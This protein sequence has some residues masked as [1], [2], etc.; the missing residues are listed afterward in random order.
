MKKILLLTTVFVSFA[1]NA[2]NT[3]PGTGNV[4]I[5]TS[6]PSN[7][8]HVV[9]DSKGVYNGDV[10][11]DGGRLV[12]GNGVDELVNGEYRSKI[13][14]DG[15][16]WMKSKSYPFLTIQ[17]TGLTFHPSMTFAIAG[18]QY[19]FSNISQQGDAILNVRVKDRSL[20]IGN[21]EKFIGND[22]KFT[23]TSVSAN[24]PW[25]SVKMIIKNNGNVGIGTENP[26][27]KLAVNG[28]IHAKEVKVDLINWPDYVFQEDYKIPSISE[29]EKHILDN[30]HLINMPSAKTIETNG[31]ELGEI[32]KLQQEKIEEL[33]LYIIELNKRLEKLENNNKNDSND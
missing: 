16:I 6:T 25:S 3:F 26:D 9:K 14:T 20:V 21:D 5:G 29:A 7:S 33:T 4:G 15:A 30:G 22:I 1:T 11:L 2:Q 10:K 17:H 12:L 13:L 19:H 18:D 24:E 8:L 23:T 31:L 32:T 27:S 28:L